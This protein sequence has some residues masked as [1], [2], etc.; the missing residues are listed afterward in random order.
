MFWKG[1]MGEKRLLELITVRNYFNCLAEYRKPNKQR[2]KGIRLI[3][4]LKEQME[5]NQML[6][7]LPNKGCTLK[8][9]N[10]LSVATVSTIYYLN[11]HCIHGD[12]GKPDSF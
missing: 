11:A 5:S 2:R 3:C 1:R 6:Q 12:K 8:E 4:H 9:K 10:L 7:S